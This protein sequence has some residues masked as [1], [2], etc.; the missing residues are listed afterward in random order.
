MKRS[1]ATIDVLRLRMKRLMASRK[2]QIRLLG[3]ILPRAIKLVGIEIHGPIDGGDAANDG[4]DGHGE[5]DQRRRGA[6]EYSG[7][8]AG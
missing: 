8:V 5:A 1:R 4:G 3:L 2:W 7:E 6:E